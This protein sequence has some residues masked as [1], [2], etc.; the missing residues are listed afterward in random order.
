[1]NRT[2]NLITASLM[3]SCIG[4]AAGA[5]TVTTSFSFSG[6]DDI[7]GGGGGFDTSTS[8][9]VGIA[10][11]GFGARASTGEVDATAKADVRAEFADAVELGTSAAVALTVSGLSGSFDTFL[12]AR[13][14]S[15]L[16]IKPFL[17]INP[18]PVT[19]G[20][21]YSL[22][23][24][25]SSSM[26]FGTNITDGDDPR[27][28][29]AGLSGF[30]GLTVRAETTLNASQDSFYKLTDLTG[31]VQATHLGT[32]TTLM[33]SFSLES[34]RFG[35]FDFGL[36]G[37][38]A[39]E[40]VGVTMKN[41]F[42]ANFGLSTGYEVGVAV[43]FNCGNLATDS[44]NGFGCVG[45]A[46][47]SGT[48]DQLTLLNGTPFQIDFGTSSASLGNINVFST[49]ISAVPLP[50]GLPMLLSALGIFG[51]LRRRRMAA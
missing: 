7:F 25:K 23:T 29:G 17:G 12:G 48:S 49:A 21:D 38:W 19:V 8:V 16:D 11:I 27:L 22:S 35:S 47:V 20:P 2:R 31:L 28:T 3:A 40:L 43:G 34:D 1:M 15:T 46:G 45:D 51:L 33:D 18:G 4:Y 50:A 10:T 37:D 5:A 42:D 36:T 30:S 9:D 24:S 44:D 14:T 39:L 13:A 26:S 32:G 6:S 41:L